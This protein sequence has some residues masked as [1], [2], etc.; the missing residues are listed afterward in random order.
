MAQKTKK[1]NQ[2]IR[3]I[4]FISI[5]AAVIAVGAQVSIPMPIGVPF[6]M[7][8]LVIP[9]AGIILGTKRGVMATV[10]YVLLGA[11]G[12]PVFAG[13]SGGI[14]ILFG[15]TGGFILSFP[16]MALCAGISSDLQDRI[17]F[18]NIWIKSAVLVS[19]LVLGALINFACGMIWG[20]IY[21]DLSWSVAFMG[22][23]APFIP[24]GV[25][26]IIIAA[27]FGATIK[28]LLKKTGILI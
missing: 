14:G 1:L 3:D 16:I 23:V 7:Q 24:T 9:F 18:K 8:T 6:T 13:F 11:A 19:G 12:V 27:G 10:I 28:K 26:K 17:K 2:R 5:F 20:K 15:R 22:F 4:C 25:A 21:L